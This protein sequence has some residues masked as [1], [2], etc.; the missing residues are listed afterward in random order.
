[1]KDV[2]TLGK[3]LHSCFVCCM[4]HMQKESRHFITME[5]LDEAISYALENPVSYEFALKP[6]GEKFQ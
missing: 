5:T 1:M 3:L 2:H 4:L 6:S